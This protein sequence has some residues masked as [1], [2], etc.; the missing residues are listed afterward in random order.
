MKPGTLQSHRKEFYFK[1][2]EVFEPIELEWLMEAP[3]NP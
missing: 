2:M 3:V 1:T